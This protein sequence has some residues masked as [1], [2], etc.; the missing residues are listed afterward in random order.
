[1]LSA[2]LCIRSLNHQYG[3]VSLLLLHRFPYDT[4]KLSEVKQCVQL[5]HKTKPNKTHLC[6]I[7]QG[8]CEGHK[9]DYAFNVLFTFFYSHKV[10]CFLNTL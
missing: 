3:F 2:L 7:L 1:M 10:L 6:D 9:S 8:G 4:E 5:N